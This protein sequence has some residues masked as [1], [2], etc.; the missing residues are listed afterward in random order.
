M[1]MSDWR[2]YFVTGLAAFG[3]AASAADAAAQYRPPAAEAV[4]EDYHIEGAY[5]WWDPEPS[6][7]VNSTAL[8]ILGDSVYADC[9]VH[10]D[11]GDVMV[12][13]TDGVSESESPSGEHFGQLRIEKCVAQLAARSS[14]EIVDGLVQEVVRWTGERGPNDD[15]TLVVLKTLGS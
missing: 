13:F 1:R 6:L 4:G 2:L 8:G 3:V 5:G 10:L 9:P 12:M 11:P 7:I 15:L 14:Q